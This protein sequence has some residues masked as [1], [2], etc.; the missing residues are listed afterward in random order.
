M[1]SKSFYR[2]HIPKIYFNTIRTF[3]H[4]STCPSKTH[5]EKSKKCDCYIYEFDYVNG[6]YY[7]DM[8]HF[9][10]DTI[11]INNTINTTNT[12]NTTNTINTNDISIF[13]DFFG[14]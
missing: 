10:I 7:I 12:L 3:T 14:D 8:C 1:F 11:N 9:G 13:D 5:C 4:C 6:N 2:I